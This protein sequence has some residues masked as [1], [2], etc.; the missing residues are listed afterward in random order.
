MAHHPHAECVPHS[1]APQI[2]PPHQG[3]S[4]T[5]RDKACPLLPLTTAWQR[6]PATKNSDAIPSLAGGSAGH[7]SAGTTTLLIAFC[8]GK[9]WA[10]QPKQT[11]T[12]SLEKTDTHTHTHTHYVPFLLLQ[13]GRGKSWLS[14][15]YLQNPAPAGSPKPSPSDGSLGGLLFCVEAHAM[16]PEVL[17]GPQGFFCWCHHAAHPSQGWCHPPSALVQGMP[18]VHPLPTATAWLSPVPLLPVPLPE[19][20]WRT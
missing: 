7:P 5:A 9:K 20:G 6:A 10:S 16:S 3:G 4:V 8:L 2:L 17:R 19:R 12:F 1:R 15:S 18:W 11:G 13:K 14:K